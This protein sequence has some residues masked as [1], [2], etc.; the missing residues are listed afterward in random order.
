[1]TLPQNSDFN[2]YTP[3]Q[4]ETQVSRVQRPA[5]TK[6]GMAILVLDVVLY[7]LIYMLAWQEPNIMLIVEEHYDLH[8]ALSPYDWVLV[9]F[10]GAAF[11]LLVLSI[12]CRTWFTYVIGAVGILLACYSNLSTLFQEWYYQ[13]EEQRDLWTQVIDLSFFVL[14][15]LASFY[16]VFRFIFGLPSRQYYRVARPKS[17]YT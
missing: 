7:G 5:S 17:V 13:E 12:G 15:T 11:P 3:P 14:I 10:I 9:H 2:P 4:T 1:M 16:L 6:W 8:Q